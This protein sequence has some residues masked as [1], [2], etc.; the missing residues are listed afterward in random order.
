[1]EFAKIFSNASIYA[2]ISRSM[3]EG[4]DKSTNIREITARIIRKL[5][6]RA[7]SWVR[8]IIFKR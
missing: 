3:C 8:N 5:W 7:N 6:Y 1:M 4:F 2:K